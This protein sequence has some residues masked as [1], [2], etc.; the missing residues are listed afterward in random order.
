MAS[1]VRMRSG[2]APFGSNQK[3]VIYTTVET[4]LGG[5][6]KPALMFSHGALGSGVQACDSPLPSRLLKALA[7]DF[8]VIDCDWGGDL[9]GN[10]VAMG[11]MNDALAWL[12]STHHANDDPPWVVGWSMGGCQALNYALD[13]EVAGVAALIPCT[14]LEYVH[15]NNVLG[16]AAVINA[17]Y[18]GV[19]DQ[20]T[21]GPL[22]DPMEF[23]ADLDP[24]IPICLFVSTADALLPNVTA[25]R[26]LWERPQTKY[27]EF[28]GLAHGLAAVGSMRNEVLSYI[29]N[30]GAYVQTPHPAEP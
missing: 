7:Q 16:Q 12:R 28:A 29:A 2:V 26:F 24:D 20:A 14:D 22:N 3:Y 30:P 4:E 8:V 25:H 10:D 9:F 1:P 21:A 27:K 18:G 6:E 23:A 15:A 19:Y 11:L 5:V 13:N 17:A